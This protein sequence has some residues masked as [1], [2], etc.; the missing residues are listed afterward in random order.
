M[1]KISIFLGTLLLG[2]IGY[3]IYDCFDFFNI[4]VLDIEEDIVNV[5]KP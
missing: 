5:D 1:K 3:I 2:F 4:P